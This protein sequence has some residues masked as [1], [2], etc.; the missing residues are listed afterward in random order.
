[1]SR[2]RDGKSEASVLV[3]CGSSALCDAV[4]PGLEVRGYGLLQA[5]SA[6]RASDVF[7][8][9]W[10]ALVFIQLPM[11]DAVAGDLT[12]DLQRLD[13]GVPLVLAGTDAEVKNAADAFDLGAYEYLEQALPEAFLAAVGSAL[14]VRK[15]D[16]QL[17]YLRQ[18]D[19]ALVGWSGLVSDSP[20]MQHVVGVLR[21]LCRR[22][23]NGGAPT[24]LLNGETGTGKGFFAKCIHYNSA[25][26]NHAFVEIN[27]AALP[28]SLMEA[29]LFGYE[30]GAFTDAKTARMGLFE[31]A[32]GGTLFLDEIAT[33]PPDLQ[34]KLLT[35]I[36]EKQVR[37]LGGR[38]STRV[39][40][41]IIAA[42]HENIE[43][44]ARAGQFRY[45]LFHRLNVVAVT[46]P[47][48]RERASDTVLLTESF[49]T[50]LCREYGMPPRTLTDGARDWIRRYSWPGNVRELRNRIE[51]IILLENDDQLRAEHFGPAPAPASGSVRL[52]VPPTGLRVALPP[53]GIPLEELERA[54]I[55]EA[56][57]QCEGNVSRAARFLSISR[58]TLIYRMKKHGLVLRHE[59]GSY[60]TLKST[61]PSSSS[62]MAKGAYGR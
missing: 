22:T 42:T 53:E 10:P 45:D 59:S 51:R 7:G 30:R 29:E 2:V 25:R 23:S 24:I 39:D 58:Q 56:L 46:I 44:R 50:T 35:A 52:S 20:A 40:V 19:A 36:E 28:P 62:A 5:T 3:V 18:K 6:A 17:Q 57:V 21:Q 32:S 49:I 12:R 43:A 26:R 37:R 61:A 13:P 38:Q 47:P 60:P 14:G 54:V 41:Q 34:A 15:G 8:D 33:L 4:L 31:A 48:L 27:C 11:P 16:V 9:H 55:R 1:M